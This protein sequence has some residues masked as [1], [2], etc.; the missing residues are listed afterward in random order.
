MDEEDT[1]LANKDLDKEVKKGLPLAAGIA[2][3][4][5]AVAGLAGLVIFLRRN[6]AGKRN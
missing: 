5:A 3:S 6:R 4:I 2:I 1:P